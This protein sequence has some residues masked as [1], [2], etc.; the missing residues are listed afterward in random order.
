MPAGLLILNVSGCG[1]RDLQGAGACPKLRL[2][3]ADRNRIDSVLPLSAL[4]ALE[5]LR[6]AYNALDGL[7]DLAKLRSL[8]VL[9]LSGHGF[10]SQSED[11]LPLSKIKGLRLLRLKD[12]PFARR[13]ARSSLGP[14]VTIFV[15]AKSEDDF[16]SQSRFRN[17]A[18]FALA[19]ATSTR[20]RHSSV[21]VRTKPHYSRNGSVSGQMGTFGLAAAKTENRATRTWQ[22]PVVDLSECRPM[23]SLSTT[24]KSRYKAAAVYATPTGLKKV[25]MDGRH[26]DTNQH[27]RAEKVSINGMHYKV[28]RGASAAGRRTK[29]ERKQ[30]GISDREAC[31]AFQHIHR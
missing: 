26:T 2:L 27:A 7:V 29:P 12:T 19:S 31:Q 18:D 6:I 1:L 5:E 14:S 4:R 22:S 17:I 30:G 15:G 25:L 23:S 10:I 9:D 3:N 13:G 28:D 11:L 21:S 20:I 8:S 24:A 16:D